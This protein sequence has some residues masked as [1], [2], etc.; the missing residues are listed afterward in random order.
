MLVAA[1]NELWAAACAGPPLIDARAS[2]RLAATHSIRLAAEVVDAVYNAAGATTIYESHVLQR[3]FQDAHVITQHIQGRRAHYE[4]VG[5]FLL[6]L[7][8]E[9]SGDTGL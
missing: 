1:A 2:M 7:P 5:R 8:I 9:E 4:L 3:Y 6:G